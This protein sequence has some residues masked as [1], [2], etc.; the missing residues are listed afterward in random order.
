[1]G[2]VPYSACIYSVLLAAS[3]LVCC[4]PLLEQGFTYPN[5]DAIFSLRLDMHHPARQALSI[6]IGSGF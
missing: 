2:L 6:T 3:A 1:M 5:L 4:A